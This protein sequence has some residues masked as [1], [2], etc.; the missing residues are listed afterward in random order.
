MC[1]LGNELLSCAHLHRFGPRPPSGDD[2][3]VSKSLNSNPIRA[4]RDRVSRLFGGVEE[5]LNPA[6]I[7]GIAPGLQQPAYAVQLKHMLKR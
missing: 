7:S 3:V 2:F 5:L 6:M 4:R 1:W